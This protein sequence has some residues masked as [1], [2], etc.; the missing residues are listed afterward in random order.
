M[1]PQV[2]GLL[3]HATHLLKAGRPGDAVVPLREAA[4]SLPGNAAILHDLG[5]ACLECGLIGEAVTA[6]RG[7]LTVD[8]GFQ[9][10]HLRLGI[11]LEAAG[12]VDDALGAYH[13]A[14]QLKPLPEASYRAGN[15]L[16]NLGHTGRA[17]EMFRRAAGSAPG[18]T[19][20][21]IAMARALLA[22]NRDAEAEKV[23]RRVLASEPNNAVALDLLGN[24]LADAGRFAEARRYFLR[25]IETA[26]WLAGSYYDVVRCS[27]IGTGTEDAELIA[28][29]HATLESQG[30]EPAQRI[31]VHLALGKAADDLGDYQ[32][33]MRQFD[34]AET[35][36]N[37]LIR[38]DLGKFEARVDSLIAHFTPELLA[39]ASATGHQRGLDDATP[40]LVVG[41]PRSGTTLVE[42]I[43]SAHPDVGAGGELSFWNE[44]GS[45]WERAGSAQA[46]AQQLSSSAVDY[47]RLLRNVA[48]AAARVTD[49]MPLNFQ[50]VGLVHLALPRATIIHC[51]RSPLDTALS[52][53]QTH[54]NPRMWFPTGGAALVGYVRAYQRLCAHWRRVLPPE[55][56]IEIDYEALVDEPEPVIQR[57]VNATGLA[58]RDVCLFPQRNTRAVKT[59]SKWQARQPIY[60]H[61]VGRWHSYEP[62]LGSLGAL[63]D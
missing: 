50:W 21:R 29:M 62:W 40:I 47:L 49:K 46:K 14:A 61:A 7:S 33:A 56:F 25:G 6:L 54:F 44:R 37:G 19:L 34:A 16:D 39:H 20:G 22:E 51:R 41:L 27:R 11:A 30:L 31:R 2:A 45:A 13:Q 38:F 24:N 48:P 58:W 4:R 55:R 53:H 43:L 3:A 57:M 8:P 26:P 63:R 28:R 12:A 5:L 42:Q 9:D 18:T 36:R 15:L 17:I 59:P 1:Q 52:I 32:E 60:R 23:L 10:S 35:L